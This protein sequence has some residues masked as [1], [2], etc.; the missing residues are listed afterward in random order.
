MKYSRSHNPSYV[1]KNNNLYAFNGERPK[2]E[3]VDFELIELEVRG[4]KQQGYL[5]DKEIHTQEIISL[6]GWMMDNHNLQGVLE[7]LGY[8]CY[9]IFSYYGAD[10]IWCIDAVNGMPICILRACI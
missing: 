1:S 10:E 3:A 5:I 9:Q 4:N 8:P 6:N 2:S 7:G